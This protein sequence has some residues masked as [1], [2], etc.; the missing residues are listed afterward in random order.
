MSLRD[1]LKKANLLSD[2]DHKRLAHE[3]RVERKEKGRETLEQEAQQRQQE[4]E[5]MSAQER[6]RT[7]VEQEKAEV[8]RRQRD[9]AAAVETLLAEAKKPGPGAVKFYFAAE[10]G[11][12]PWLELSP[13]EA[14]EL[15]AG[16]LCVVRRGAPGTHSYRLL[17]LEATRRVARQRPEAVVL[18]PR[19]V[20]TG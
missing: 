19:G 12:L 17:G 9:E 11:S 6:E 15:R 1:Q 18:A 7:R 5:A 14:Q 10:D 2:K 16:Q 8:A 13:R 4:I 20:V 3:A